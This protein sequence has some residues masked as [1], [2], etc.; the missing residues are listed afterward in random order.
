MVKVPAHCFISGNEIADEMANIG[1]KCKNVVAPDLS[2]APAW[3][4]EIMF[5]GEGRLDTTHKSLSDKFFKKRQRNFDEN[6]RKNK[7]AHK[8]YVESIK[9]LLG[10]F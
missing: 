6:L 7:F 3:N 4:S 8:F 9:T 2:I 5:E 1:A 10:F